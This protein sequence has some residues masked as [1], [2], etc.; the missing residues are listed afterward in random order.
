[1]LDQV[2]KSCIF[3]ITVKRNKSFYFYLFGRFWRVNLK[4]QKK[5]LF[6]NGITWYKSYLSCVFCIIIIYFYFCQSLFSVWPKRETHSRARASQVQCVF[7]ALGASPPPLVVSPLCEAIAS[8]P[9]TFSLKQTLC[10]DQTPGVKAHMLTNNRL[11][12]TDSGER[13]APGSWWFNSPKF[14]HLSLTGTSASH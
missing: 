4:I 13:L 8:F 10:R 6:R 3:L 5:S 14:W 9:Q 11:H 7:R 1:M 2:C 12:S